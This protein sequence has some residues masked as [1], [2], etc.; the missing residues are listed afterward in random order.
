MINHNVSARTAVNDKAYCEMSNVPWNIV[1]SADDMDA[2][3][4][5]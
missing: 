1:G 5:I 3:M 4:N 2:M